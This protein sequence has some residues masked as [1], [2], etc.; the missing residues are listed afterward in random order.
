VRF[1]VVQP[2]PAFSVQDVYAGWVEALRGL[3]QTVIEFNLDARL[4]FYAS[5]EFEVNGQRRKLNDEEAT[6]LAV[7]GLCTALYKVR[8]DV[9]VIVSGFFIPYALMDLVRGAYGTRI[10]VLHTESPYE[11]GRQMKAAE[12]ADLNLLNDPT[13]LDQFRAVSPT[14]YM[15]HAYRPA[16]HHPGPAV[17]DLVCDFGFVGTGYESRIQFLEQM[18]LDGLDVLLGGNWQQLTNDSPLRKYVGHDIDQC[19]DNAETADLYRSARVGMNLYRREAERPELSTGWAM[20]PRE[21]EMAA[22]G[23]FFLRDPRGEGDELLPTLPTFRGPGEASDLLRW[24]LGH[25]RLRQD[26]AEAARIAV[27]DRTF[28]NHARQ[29]MRL[30]ETK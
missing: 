16:L 28:D 20:G 9:L 11:D 19:L 21:V 12:H 8:P 25:E 10:V 3:G 5:G 7:D 26:A 22:C 29:L 18:N 24:W 15:P 27:A 13:N 2:G 6:G 1:L 17:S 30:L 14:E 23:L 4:T